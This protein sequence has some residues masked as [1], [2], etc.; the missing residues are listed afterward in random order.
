MPKPGSS[1]DYDEY[2]NRPQECPL[3]QTSG[4]R[5][6][7]WL[8]ATAERLAVAKGDREAAA[9]RAVVS[10]GLGRHAMAEPMLIEYLLQIGCGQ[11]AL[12]ALEETLASGILSDEELAG[13]D[14]ALAD[15][16]DP[17]GL[18]VGL[19]GERALNLSVIRSLAEGHTSW[20]DLDVMYRD[21]DSRLWSPWVWLVSPNDLVAC[22]DAM[23]AYVEAAEFPYP[24]RMDRLD[25]AQA[26]A[27]AYKSDGFGAWFHPA[28]R[29]RLF[30]YGKS[31][32][33]DAEW[34]ARTRAA[35]VAVAL[36]RAK[37][38]FGS[39]PDTLDEIAANLGEAARN[40]MD[41]ERMVYQKTSDG[42]V[43]TTGTVIWTGGKAAEQTS[44]GGK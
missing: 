16:Y 7:A 13:V 19:V 5:R 33:E 41:G 20:S 21:K 11:M 32:E 28:T 18:K 43:L 1:I 17:D 35:R 14:R 39:Y 9:R 8:V 10:L 40:P 44:P 12:G 27:R 36:E 2:R 37:L 23:T 34:L 26:K 25:A 42:Y 24:E 22:A 38:R 29:L 31:F 15:H 4:L 30:D 3:P 6:A